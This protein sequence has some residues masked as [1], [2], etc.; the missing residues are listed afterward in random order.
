[1]NSLSAGRRRD[2]KPG[3]AQPIEGQLLF[4]RETMVRHWQQ[5]LPAG[6]LVVRETCE[7][8]GKI[9]TVRNIQ[10]LPAK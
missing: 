5:L 7:D 3:C 10:S 8:G 2:E 1:V 9:G 6:H 4:I